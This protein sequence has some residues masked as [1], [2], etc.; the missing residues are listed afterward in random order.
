[1]QKPELHGEKFE[2]VGRDFVEP[3]N[4]GNMLPT[5]T[6]GYP[7]DSFRT[8]ASGVRHQLAEMTVV[9]TGQLVLNQDRRSHCKVLAQDIRAEPADRFLQALTLK[10][11]FHRF[12]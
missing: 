5:K 8:E 11:D 6:G 4:G 2:P 12:S 7:N 1:L 9:G 3:P 10:G